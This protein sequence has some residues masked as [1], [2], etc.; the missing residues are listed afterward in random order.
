MLPLSF[1][2][3][4]CRLKYKFMKI[5]SINSPTAVLAKSKVPWWKKLGAG[6]LSISILIHAVILVIGVVVI[7][8]IIPPPPEK[9]VDFIAPGGGGGSAANTTQQKKRANVV[10]NNASRVAAKDVVSN[11]TLP[12]PEASSDMSAL[13]ALGAGGMGGLGGL[14]KGATPSGGVG[15]GGPAGGMGAGLGSGTSVNPFG[16]IDPNASALIGTFYDTKQT[17]KREPS[18]T[19]VVGIVK[20][21]ING[22]WKPRDL[23]KYY[24]PP[25]QLY[26]T[27]IYIPQMPADEAP[28]AFQC[29]KE[30]QPS[31]WIVVYRGTV[32]PPKT[33]K[34]HFVGAGDDILVVRFNKKN[35]F[36]YGYMS[37]ICGVGTALNSGNLPAFKGEVEDKELEK[38]LGRDYIMPL[39]LTLYPYEKMGWNSPLGGLARGPEFEAVAG[40]PYPIEILICEVPGG[41]F[42]AVLMIEE[43][44]VKYRKD[45]ETGSPILPIFR[46]DG[47]SPK[48]DRDNHNAPPFDRK[49]PVWTLMNESGKGDI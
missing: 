33:G 29:E 13:G 42:G 34:Y 48:V 9:V 11:F 41:S 32:T 26:Q 2:T 14:G 12:D 35:V 8:Q 5:T 25:R 20:N 18:E 15:S 30:V 22:G 1:E 16:M 7:V 21:F 49:G 17:P 6:S 45:S 43:V 4:L 36:D 40:T 38:R 19:P 27:K 37:G 47:N 46:L 10:R 39:P 24:Q 3:H 44:G 23:D 31:R 28:A